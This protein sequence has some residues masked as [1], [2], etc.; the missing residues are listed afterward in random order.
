MTCNMRSTKEAI[1]GDTFFL[2]DRPVEPLMEVTKPKPMVYA[3]FYPLDPIEQACNPP[4]N[5][6]IFIIS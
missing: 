5:W 1:I 3:G 2:K 6:K 4:D